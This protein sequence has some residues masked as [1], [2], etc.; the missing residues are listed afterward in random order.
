MDLQ[1][2]RYLTFDDLQLYCYRVAST[3]G[4][5]CIEIFGYKHQS[6]RDFAVNLGVALQLTNILRDIKKDY[7]NGRIYLPQEDLQQFNYTESDIASNIYNTNFQEL[8]KYEAERAKQYF[9]RAT[10]FL[11]Q[12]LWGK[13]EY[14]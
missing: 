13:L 6:T 7:Q 1:K 10:H 3:V 8:M 4:L 11:K 14:G 12:G 2:N 5:M 9:D